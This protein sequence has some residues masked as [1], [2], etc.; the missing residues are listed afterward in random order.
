MAVWTDCYNQLKS[1]LPMDSMGK[2]LQNPHT[3]CSRYSLNHTSY[4]YVDC[5]AAIIRPDHAVWHHLDRLGCQCPTHMVR[6][7][8]L[9]LTLLGWGLGGEPILRHLPAQ[10]YRVL[11]ATFVPYIKPEVPISASS[12]PATCRIVPLTPKA[13]PQKCYLQSPPLRLWENVS[14]LQTY[15]S[16]FWKQVLWSY[17][18]GKL[19]FWATYGGKA[20]HS[21]SLIL[22]DGQNLQQD[23][24]QHPV[25]QSLVPGRLCRS[26]QVFLSEKPIRQAGFVNNIRHLMVGDNRNQGWN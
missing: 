16:G 6:Q 4:I 14:H 12:S 19:T 20:N 2:K 24:S 8:F 11:P 15:P 25:E 5:S 26:L 23:L 21:K 1:S 18:N 3:A 10:R 17:Y 13:E 7:G 22:P 9:M